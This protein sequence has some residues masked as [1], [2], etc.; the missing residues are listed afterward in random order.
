MYLSTSEKRYFF[1]R[2]LK[3]RMHECYLGYNVLKT[4]PYLTQRQNGQR[5]IHITNTTVLMDV[6]YIND[7]M[8]SFVAI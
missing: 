2:C 7:K 1:T 4:K 8:Q 5:T 6:L 3:A